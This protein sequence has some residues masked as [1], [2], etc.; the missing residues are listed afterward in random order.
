MLIQSV[1]SE[2]KLQDGHQMEIWTIG[3]W[4]AGLL[5]SC[6][7]WTVGPFDCYNVKYQM[8]DYPTDSCAISPTAFLFSILT[9]LSQS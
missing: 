2:Q 5:D 8:D 1:G 9:S 3:L 6:K 7:L 4:T